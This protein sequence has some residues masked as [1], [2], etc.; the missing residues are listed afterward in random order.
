MVNQNFLVSNFREML[1]I[2]E[3]LRVSHEPGRGMRHL[4][5]RPAVEGALR[6]SEAELIINGKDGEFPILLEVEGIGIGHELDRQ[7]ETVPLSAVKHVFFQSEKDR[8]IALNRSFENASFDKLELTINE[9][10]FSASGEPRFSK[11][12]DPAN[13]ETES[14]RNADWVCGGLAAA[15]EAGRVHPEC[16]KLGAS[17]LL[18]GLVG[19][20]G[21]KGSGMIPAQLE[22][23][24]KLVEL[25]SQNSGSGD[26]YGE[27]LLEQSMSALRKGNIQ[28]AVLDSFAERMRAILSSDIAR[29]PGE[30]TDEGQIALRALSILIQRPTTHDVLE[31]RVSGD[32]PGPQVFV[33]AAFLSGVREGLA[34]LPWGIKANDMEAL[35]EIGAR[36]ENGEEVHRTIS[37]VLGVSQDSFVSPQA[38]ANAPEMEGQPHLTGGGGKTLVFEICKLGSKAAAARALS[39]L[40]DKPTS[41]RITCGDEDMLFLSICVASEE[42][43]VAQEAEATKA[44]RSWKKR[45]PATKKAGAKK[46]AP[47][48]ETDTIPGLLDQSGK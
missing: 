46:N 5:R 41:W 43:A 6:S 15:L 10:L 20:I 32:F 23:L 40:A 21:E 48:S 37:N 24:E 14:W 9:S 1:T 12:G 11:A 33:M 36:I 44:L 4:E 16:S 35:G 25:L 7:A 18:P 47:A 13:R 28:E 17:Q 8:D 26:L 34:R 30:L 45:A 22:T 19:A 29:K 39:G 31:D 38:H 3:C 27:D 2:L 42:D